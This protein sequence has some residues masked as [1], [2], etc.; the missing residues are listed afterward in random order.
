MCTYQGK[1]MAWA[2][3]GTFS[4]APMANNTE[5]WTKYRAKVVVMAKEK[6]C[7]A[8]ALRTS[9]RRKIRKAKRSARLRRDLA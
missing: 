7:A 3:V 1:P 4:A 6:H 2:V 9:W 5:R 8:V